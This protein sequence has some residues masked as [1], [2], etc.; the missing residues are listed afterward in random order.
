MKTIFVVTSVVEKGRGQQEV[1]LGAYIDKQEAEQVAEAAL[2]TKG[3]V[4]CDNIT[5]RMENGYPSD[6]VRQV[7]G[8]TTMWGISRQGADWYTGTSFWMAAKVDEIILK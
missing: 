8:N 1:I 3:G 6:V 4:L 5:W 2:T 7:E